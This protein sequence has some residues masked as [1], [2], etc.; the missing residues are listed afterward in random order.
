[1]PRTW[2]VAA[3]ALIAGA[4]Y[5]AWLWFGWG[6]PALTR[7]VD[8]VGLAVFALVAACCV[9]WAALSLRGPDRVAWVF[10]AAGLVGWTAGEVIWSYY[11]L[12]VGDAPS[13]SWADAGYV[14][15]LVGAGMCLIVQLTAAPPTTQLRVVIDGLIVAAAIFAAVW[16]IWLR[17]VYV[18]RHSDVLSVAVNLVYPVTDIALVT[19]AGLMVLRAPGAR[20]DQLSLLFAGLVGVGVSDV[21]FAYISA[22][23]SYR[24][25][26]TLAVGWAMGFLLIAAAAVQAKRVGAQGAGAQSPAVSGWL[27]YVPVL[28]SAVLC[29]PVLVDGMGPVF[30]AVAVIVFAVTVRQVVLIGENRRLRADIAASRADAGTPP[31]LT[32]L[33]H[34]V[35]HGDLRLVYQPQYDLF[36]EDIIGVEALVRWPHPRRGLLNPDQ[37]LPLVN[38]RTLMTKLTTAVVDLALADAAVWHASGFPIPVAVNVFAPTVSDPA[39]SIGIDDALRRHGLA[40]KALTVEI[41]EDRLLADM[42]GTRSALDHLRVSGIQVALDDFGSGYS[43]LWYLRDFPVDQVK[44]DREFIAPILTHGPS[45]TIVRAVIEMTHALGLTPVAEG[46][47]SAQTAARLREYGCRVAQGFY[48]SRPVP[49]A[50]VLALLEAQRRERVLAPGHH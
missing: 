42:P 4:G 15:F 39:L 20:R 33:E 48:F 31:I 25:N 22:T 34:A 29:T 7:V 49:G 47:E 2:G 13:P 11:D 28:L 36:T 14:L 30:V 45:A 12:V 38:Q 43:A 44:L 10:M 50:E 26:R 32:E 40:P 18:A 1:M 35:E 5:G 21:A 16:V 46:V 9:A 8:D 17:T 6:G 19:V 27:P 24:G 23:D 3:A 41:T 37:F